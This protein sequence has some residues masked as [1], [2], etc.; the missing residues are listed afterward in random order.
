MRR[1]DAGG[2][3]DDEAGRMK[4]H[5]V[6]SWIGVLVEDVLQV[7]GTLYVELWLRP[8]A[9]L[10]AGTAGGGVSAVAALSLACGLAN[11]VFKVVGGVHR[12]RTGQLDSV[13]RSETDISWARPPAARASPRGLTRGALACARRRLY[14]LKPKY[15]DHLIAKLG[16]SSAR[17]FSMMSAGLD[18]DG[19]AKL[20]SGVLRH[21][22][23]L[24]TL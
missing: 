21:M 5:G 17:Y 8:E 11:A 22:P 3:Q 18:D 12:Q 1:C 14:K 24:E 4:W 20:A 9:A 13:T 15:D 7:L 16:A 6:I 19:M 23:R 2:A 10:V